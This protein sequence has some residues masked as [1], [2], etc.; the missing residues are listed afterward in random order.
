MKRMKNVIWCVYVSLLY[1]WWLGDA[2]FIVFFVF[3][4]VVVFFFFFF[5][6]FFFCFFL[7]VF[8]RHRIKMQLQ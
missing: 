5:F 6:F 7:C 4:F 8:V 3:F 2:V 1:V